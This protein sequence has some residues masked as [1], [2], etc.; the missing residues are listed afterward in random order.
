VAPAQNAP[1]VSDRAFNPGV[2]RK[3]DEWLAINRNLAED[4]PRVTPFT[5][6]DQ[7]FAGL[8]YERIDDSIG[9]TSSLAS[10]IWRAFLILMVAALILEAV[11]CMPERR[12][13]SA[14]F[15]R[16]IQKQPQEN[17]G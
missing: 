2:Y 11:L 13:R 3:G 17:A 4:D 8:P 10:E 5:E 9:D 14:G 6:I 12:N 1:T 7:L 15:S 16:R